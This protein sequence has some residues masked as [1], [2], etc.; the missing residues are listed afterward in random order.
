LFLD[1]GWGFGKQLRRELEVEKGQNLF[2]IKPS[3]PVIRLRLDPTD[4]N[5]QFRVRNLRLMEQG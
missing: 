1:L 2:L 4:D 3:K 5:A